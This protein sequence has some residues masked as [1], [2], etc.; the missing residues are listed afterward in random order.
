MEDTEDL[1]PISAREVKSLTYSSPPKVASYGVS[2]REQLNNVSPTPLSR[3][4]D[5]LSSANTLTMYLEKDMPHGHNT[6]TPGNEV[7]SSIA[8]AESSD[9]MIAATDQTTPTPRRAGRIAAGLKRAA[10]LKR[11]REGDDEV[12]GTETDGYISPADSDGS[13]YTDI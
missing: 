1:P 5:S 10:E 12:S 6:S 2:V 9:G 11:M 8:Y 7:A 3:S 4:K 13:R